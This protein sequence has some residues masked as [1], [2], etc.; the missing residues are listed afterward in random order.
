M[1][2]FLPP[3]YLRIPDL[4]LWLWL[5]LWT[6]RQR[7]TISN[8][9]PLF[10]SLYSSITISR[11][12]VPLP[13]LACNTDPA[14]PSYPRTH[15]S[16]EH[17]PSSLS[18]PGRRP[19]LPTSLSHPSFRPP[20]FDPLQPHRITLPRTQLEDALASCLLRCTAAGLIPFPYLPYRTLPCLNSP[21]STYLP[22]Y[23][24]LLA[25]L[26]DYLT[27]TSPHLADCPPTSFPLPQLLSLS[28]HYHHEPDFQCGLPPCSAARCVDGLVPGSNGFPSPGCRRH[29]PTLTLYPWQTMTHR[30]HA[31]STP[32]RQHGQRDRYEAPYHS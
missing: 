9:I 14:L 10:F 7:D 6:R 22:T 16:H 8:R 3:P 31:F 2:T 1:L 32:S 18:F 21:S 11:R 23:L 25:C 13:Y 29:P 19:F 17:F 30:R 27:W 15:T 4:W 12:K 28:R 26:T 5:W 20:L 24:I